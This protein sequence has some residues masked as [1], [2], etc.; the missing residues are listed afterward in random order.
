MF[1]QDWPGLEGTHRPVAGQPAPPLHILCPLA[2]SAQSM[3]RKQRQAAAAREGLCVSSVQQL[4]LLVCVCVGGGVEA[5][6]SW[7]EMWLNFTLEQHGVI[8]Q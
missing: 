3:I 8:S 4:H 2:T 6:V 1:S 5:V 7:S